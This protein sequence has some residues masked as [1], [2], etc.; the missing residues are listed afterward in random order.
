M[1][2]K[3][4]GLVPNSEDGSSQESNS[5]SEARRKHIVSSSP[6]VQS[7]TSAVTSS[8]A[9]SSNKIDTK[10]F[11]EVGKDAAFGFARGLNNSDAM[12]EVRENA[13]WLAQTAYDE[14]MYAL[15]EH[16][17]SKKMMQVGEYAGEGFAIGLENWIKAAGEA[18]YNV[19]DT[20]LDSLREALSNASSEIQ[21]DEEFNPT[22]TPVLDLSNIEENAGRI[23]GILNVDTPIQLAA[24]AGMSFSGGVNGML[25]NIQ[26]SMPE[27]TDVGIVDAINEMRYDINQMADSIRQM[28]IVMDTGELVGVITQ[29]IDDLL[30]FNSMLNR[31]GVR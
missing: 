1:S 4:P 25:S 31:R 22:I 19:G 13:S 8:Q 28:Q 21:N 17:P 26:A 16:S 20:A 24:N 30:G 27:F 15:D 7:S 14:A 3:S 5:L 10:S 2:D 23:G 12:R 6:V 9:V 29:P 11:Y 18:G